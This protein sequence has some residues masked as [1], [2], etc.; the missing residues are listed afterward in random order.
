MNT[1]KNSLESGIFELT[2]DFFKHYF[3]FLQIIVDPVFVLE[4]PD[5]SFF[6]VGS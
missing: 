4:E 5:Q 1:S 3:H 6:D 2:T